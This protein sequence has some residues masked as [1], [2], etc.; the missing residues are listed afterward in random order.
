GRHVDG[1]ELAIEIADERDAAARRQHG[2]EERRA[3][4]ERPQ[5]VERT[6]LVSGE[7]ADVAIRARHLEEPAVRARATAARDA[8]DLAR[9]HLDAA[10]AQRDD[11]ALRR[12]VVAR[13]LPIVTTLGAR[14]R[15][16]PLAHLVRDDV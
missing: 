13:G 5:L 3:L 14:A 15:L 11:D 7:L 4:L 10:L 2:R 1:F 9:P 16:H 8:L 6:R 12:H